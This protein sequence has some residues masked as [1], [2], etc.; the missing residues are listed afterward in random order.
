[1]A[2]FYPFFGGVRFLSFITGILHPLLTWVI[3]G[4]RIN[5]LGDRQNAE[6]RSFF[7]D[8]SAFYLWYHQQ[9]LFSDYRPL[10]PSSFITLFKFKV[11]VSQVLVLVKLG[12]RIG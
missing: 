1:M 8:T 9:I 3:K 4:C 11:K 10:S 5:P 2:L 7:P 12:F 6:N